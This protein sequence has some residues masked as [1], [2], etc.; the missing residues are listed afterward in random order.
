MDAGAQRAV[1]NSVS[2]TPRIRKFFSSNVRPGSSWDDSGRL[3]AISKDEYKKLVGRDFNGYDVVQAFN[4][5]VAANA[6][7]I[8]NL[9]Y[10]MSG[11]FWVDVEG[12]MKGIPAR[13]N[14]KIVAF[15]FE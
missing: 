1:R 11:N 14:I 8:T 2:R 7:D 15:D 4:G 10:W 3:L 13:V 9:S 12:G 6:F 5:D